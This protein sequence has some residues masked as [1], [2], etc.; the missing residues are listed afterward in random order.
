[1][2]E[3]SVRHQAALRFAEAGIPVFPCYPNSKKPATERGFHDATTDISVID[4]WWAQ[5]DYNLA[6]SP[7]DAGWGIIDPDGPEGEAAWAKLVAEHGPIETYTV[8]TPRGGRHLYFEGTLPT[9]AWAPGRK[10]CLGDH[11]DTRG[12]GSYALLPP[13]T[14]E[15]KPYY[16]EKDIEL[17]PVPQWAVDRLGNSATRVRSAVEGVDEPANIHRA[18]TF[19]RGA[20]GRG[21][22]AVEGYGGNNRT[23]TLAC[24]LLNLGLSAETAQ[25][26]IEEI[27]NPECLPPWDDA[28]LVQI[29]GNAASYAQNASGAWATGSAA[30]TFGA[31]LD[32]LPAEVRSAPAR[33]SRFHFEDLDE[34]DNAPDPEWM[35]QDLIPDRSTVLVLAKSGHF[36]SFI[37]QD[38]LMSIT[39]GTQCFGSTPRRRGPVFY[40][41]H[42]GRNEIKKARKYAWLQ[43][44]DVE[45][46]AAKGFFVA[47]APFV[48]MHEQCEEFREQIRIRLRQGAEKIGGIVLDTAAKCMMGLDENSA[49][50]CGIFIAFC[51][52]LRDEFECPVIVLHHN[53]ENTEKWGRGSTAL[54]AGFDTI[55]G[56]KRAEDTMAVEVRAL[57]HKDAEERKAPWTFEGRKIGPSLVFYP[58]DAK[59]YRTITH[60]ADI[61]DGRKIGQALA[62][63]GAYGFAK[64]VTG[65]VL[66]SLVLPPAED[67]APEEAMEAQNRTARALSGLARSKLSAYGTKAGREWLWHLPAP[68]SE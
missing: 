27:W 4:G 52:S 40:G 24:D 39:T 57:Q 46:E 33:R 5:A 37:V 2:Q 48:A 12:V 58:L 55:I 31:A 41:A 25:Q 35:I 60:A 68:A 54:I 14:F 62:T 6:F 17:A 3:K 64:A 22:V 11:I 51:D 8:R 42:E 18:R 59:D 29:I 10:R 9:S 38:I 45:R 67:T 66:A 56:I 15:G 34:Q 23:Y 32:Q 47:P 30:D 13:S 49:R 44:H 21:D 36:K 50:D 1:M 16:V 26:L 7:A 61:F 65:A 53:G 63:L 28:E 19:L 43:G 20:V